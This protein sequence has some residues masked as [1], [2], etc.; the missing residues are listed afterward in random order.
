MF[1]PISDSDLDQCLVSL[2]QIMLEKDPEARAI[3]ALVRENSL[4]LSAQRKDEGELPD[5]E[6][7]VDAC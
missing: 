7:R 2:L 6:V 4:L 5:T 3:I 1:R